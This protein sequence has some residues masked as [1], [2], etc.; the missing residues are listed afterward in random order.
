MTKFNDFKNKI[1]LP[2]RLFLGKALLFYIIW[3]VLYALFIH[4]SPFPQQFLTNHVGNF[5]VLILN[6]LGDMTGFSCTNTSL[7]SNY[8]GELIEEFYS[9]IYHYEKK[10]LKIANAC[11]G[12]TLMALYTG[13]IVCMPSLFWRKIKYILIGLIVIDAI[14]I[15][16]C[17]GLI[18]LSEYYHTYFDFAHHYLFKAVIYATTFLLW[19]IFARKIHLNHENLQNG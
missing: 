2:I 3:E 6:N 11:N 4:E 1:P 10:I 12:L 17:V 9:E 15:I 13:F 7:I 8:S 5:S 18:Y 16:R 19:Y 14:N